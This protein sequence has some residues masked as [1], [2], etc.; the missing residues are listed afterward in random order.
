MVAMVPE[1]ALR[2][3]VV[4]LASGH[5]ACTLVAAEEAAGLSD[6]LK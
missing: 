2:W 3:F 5:V 4:A 6:E 1:D